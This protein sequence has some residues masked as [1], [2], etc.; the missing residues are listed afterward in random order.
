MN[1]MEIKKYDIANG[2][3]VR[4]SL[5]VSG[6]THHCKNC[7]NP[8]S[9]D[10]KAGKVFDE[11]A[12]K[13]ILESLE[14]DYIKGF[15]LLGGEPFEPHNQES[16]LPL[17]KEIKKQKPKLNIWCYT[18]Y[19]F[20]KQIIDVM[21]KKYDFTNEL[22]KYIDVIVDGEY[23]EEERDLSIIFRGSRNQR[24]IDVQKS[25]KYGKIVLDS[26][27]DVKLGGKKWKD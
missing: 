10:F 6:C 17:L 12:Q 21:T 20:D 11:T 24:I 1:Y 8:E 9:W 3:G 26:H 22:L 25:L 14:P 15:S 23:K 18:G 13:E 7:F 16:L 5:F 27:N 4:V 2:P 19:L